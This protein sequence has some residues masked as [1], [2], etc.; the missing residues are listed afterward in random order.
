MSDKKPVVLAIALPKE[1]W[2]KICKDYS[3][4]FTI[5]QAR[6]HEITVVSY[7]NS[8][9]AVHLLPAKDPCDERQTKS[10]V[11]FPD[12]LLLECFAEVSVD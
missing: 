8:K 9:P 7:P 6:W 3:D 12:M 11:I 1:N 4:V 2:Y 5:E 10:R